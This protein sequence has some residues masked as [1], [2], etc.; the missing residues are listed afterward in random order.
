MRT[1]SEHEL[2]EFDNFRHSVGYR[3]M[4]WEL[5]NRLELLDGHIFGEL[6]S[7]ADIAT[8]QQHIGGKKAIQDFIDSHVESI[9]TRTQ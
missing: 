6:R 8:Q 1:F 2:E 7:I 3:V 4:L 9:K 5:Q